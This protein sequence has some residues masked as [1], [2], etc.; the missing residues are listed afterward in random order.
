MTN[1]TALETAALAALNKDSE[2][3]GHDFFILEY[4]EW[5]DR[6]QLGGLVTS[7][8][9]KGII[10]QIAKHTVNDNEIITQGVL[11]EEFQSKV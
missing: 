4:V 10:T 9:A 7:L 2:T 8:Q 11:A 6:K 5:D 1:L 3:N